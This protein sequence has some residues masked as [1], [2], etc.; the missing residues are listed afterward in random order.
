MI[1][2]GL[3]AYVVKLSA[4]AR[5]SDDQLAAVGVRVLV[6]WA[7]KSR[8]HDAGEAAAVAQRVLTR[9]TVKTYPEA[10]HALNGEYPA[11]IAADVAAFLG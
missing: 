10:S 7:G 4:P 11:E 6:L 5:P 8:L 1:E 9:G 3:Q 2:A